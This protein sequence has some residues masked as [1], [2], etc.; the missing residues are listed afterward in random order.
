MRECAVGGVYQVTCK[1]L[2]VDLAEMAV[3]EFGHPQIVLGVRNHLIDAVAPAGRQRVG[4]MEFLPIA[5][6][7]IEPE[8]VLGA[9]ALGPDFAVDVVAQPDEVELH[10]IVVPLR[11]AADNI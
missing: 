1:R 8:D 5:A 11:G 3:V 10:A 6:R 4:R 7:Q 2:G 9:D